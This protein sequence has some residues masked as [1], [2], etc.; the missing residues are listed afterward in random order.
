[1]SP[2]TATC[3]PSRAKAALWKALRSAGVTLV[4]LPWAISN[5]DACRRSA[6]PGQLGDRVRFALIGNDFGEK[7]GAYAVEN[8]WYSRLRVPPPRMSA[9]SRAPRPRRVRPYDRTAPSIAW[10][11]AAPKCAR[12]SASPCAWRFAPARLGG[13]G[14]D[15]EP[16]ARF[17]TSYRS[18]ALTV[19]GSTSPATTRTALLGV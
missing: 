15:Q 16:S 9:S 11:S 1:M 5:T 3:S 18:S 6:P 10:K 19:S 14:L 17:P 7:L 12:R 4:R 8:C 2:T 13:C